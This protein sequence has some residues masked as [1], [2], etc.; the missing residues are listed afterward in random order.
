MILFCIFKSDIC[1]AGLD[2]MIT[3]GGDFFKFMLASSRLLSVIPAQAG[4]Q[5]DNGDKG[6]CGKISEV[7]TLK[8]PEPATLSKP[9]PV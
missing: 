5:A 4:I 9:G 6:Q 1:F 3:A 8:G 7:M 2:K